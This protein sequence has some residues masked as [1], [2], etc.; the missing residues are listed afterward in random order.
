MHLFGHVDRAAGVSVAFSPCGR[1]LATGS[2]T[3]LLFIGSENNQAYIYDIRKSSVVSKLSGGHTDVVMSVDFN[4]I[5]QEIV[6]GGHDG[7][8]RVWRHV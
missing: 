4:P 5:N 3:T 8:I 1:Y 2:P 6:T 7:K